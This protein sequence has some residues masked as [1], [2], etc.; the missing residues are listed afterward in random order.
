[1]SSC[2]LSQG[3]KKHASATEKSNRPQVSAVSSR[4]GGSGSSWVRV[5]MRLEQREY[6][7]VAAEAAWGAPGSA[8]LCGMFHPP[9]SLGPFQGV[10]CACAM[11]AC[12]VC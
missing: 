2:A 12:Y 3:T 1:M 4:A 5:K 6:G 8:T 11:R 7:Y 10:L 9:R